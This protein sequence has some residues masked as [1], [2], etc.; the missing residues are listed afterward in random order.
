MIKN[1]TFSCIIFENGFTILSF[2]GKIVGR[3]REIPSFHCT[4][5][6]TVVVQLDGVGGVGDGGDGG[7][8]GRRGGTDGGI[9]WWCLWWYRYSW[10]LLV[11]WHWLVVFVV[12]VG[13]IGIHGVCLLVLVSGVCGGG[14]WCVGIRGV[15]NVFFKTMHTS[16]VM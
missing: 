10:C 2:D 7:V 3:T 11:C 14:Y 8:C 13:G 16:T 12:I 15:C 9:G 6:L 5:P 4:V 1:K